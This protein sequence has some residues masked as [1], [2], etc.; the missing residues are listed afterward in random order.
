MAL[1]VSLLKMNCW[2]AFRKG[3]AAN[4]HLHSYLDV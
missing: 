3:H 2:N 4:L 1:T